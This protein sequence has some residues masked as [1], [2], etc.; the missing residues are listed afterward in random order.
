MKRLVVGDPHITV[1]NLE[2]SEKLM[3]FINDLIL[4]HKPDRV[5]ILGDAFHNHAV[6]RLEV[7]EFWKEWLDILS[8]AQELFV[9]VG[10]HDMSGDYNSESHALSV[11]QKSR[12][13]NL[14]IISNP[15]H[16]GIFAYMPYYH[17][18]QKFI[19]HANNLA[20]QGAKILVCHATFSGA[21]FENGMYAPDGIDPT[22]LKFDTIISG[23][24]HAHQEFGNVIYPGTARWMTA[25]DANQ[26]KGIWIYEHNDQTGALE[27][28]IFINSD[29]ACSKI[30]SYEIKEGSSE[31]FA[32]LY[33][34]DN[35]RVFV[36]L[37]GSASWINK[38]KLEFKGKASIKTRITDNKNREE[39]K[40]GIDLSD[41]I[42]NHF[43]T[44]LNKERLLKFLKEWNL[45]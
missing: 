44:S 30:I 23:H 12:K 3:H 10:N 7:L 32:E 1:S 8:E 11:F 38:K 4:E 41:F 19:E 31:D 36:E 34:P 27:G 28:S 22:L 43:Q 20:A 40:S 33:L 24:I 26:A 6:I 17:D 29:K 21:K 9:L 42:T 5:E 25:S 16:H 15:Q 13:K 35:A 14:R 45:V 39:R 37:I 2:E 18:K